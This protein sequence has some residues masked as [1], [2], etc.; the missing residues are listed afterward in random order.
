MYAIGENKKCLYTAKARV[1]KITANM[2]SALSV[3]KQRIVFA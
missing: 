3:L 1:Q 2:K